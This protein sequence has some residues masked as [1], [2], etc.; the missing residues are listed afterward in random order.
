[1]MAGFGVVVAWPE[2]AVAFPPPGTYLYDSHQVV[3]PVV[4]FREEGARRLSCRSRQKSFEIMQ[5]CFFLLFSG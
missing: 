1:M 3:A 2:D 5:K 4:D